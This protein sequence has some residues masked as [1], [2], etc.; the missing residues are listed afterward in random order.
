MSRLTD[1]L[2]GLSEG[3]ARAPNTYSLGR[4]IGIF[5]VIL[6]GVI[7]ALPNLYPPDYALQIRAEAPDAKMTQD[8]V[9]RATK[10]L[11]AGGVRIKGAHMDVKNA[12]LRL[13]T[14]DDQLRG[15]ELVQAALQADSAV[16]SQFVVA[17]NLASTTPQ[18][19]QSLGAKPM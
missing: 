8:I 7:Y 12:V 11:E 5:F 15:S 13:Y 10:A 18:W 2:L 3:T 4:Y 16:A 19:L 17:L 1:S 9:D 14:N 6:I